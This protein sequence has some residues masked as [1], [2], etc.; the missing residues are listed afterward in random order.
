MGDLL[1]GFLVYGLLPSRA[2]AISLVFNPNVAEVA[3]LQCEFGVPYFV[4]HVEGCGS[5]KKACLLAGLQLAVTSCLAVKTFVFVPMAEEGGQMFVWE[6]L[7]L[8]GRW[9]GM[10]TPGK[11]RQSGQWGE[12]RDLRCWERCDRSSVSLSGCMS[13]EH[14]F[15]AVGTVAGSARLPCY[16]VEWTVGTLAQSGH[17]WEVVELQADLGYSEWCK[18]PAFAGTA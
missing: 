5:S 11:H 4:R 7:V 10:L 2:M 18:D 13:L 12:G 15:A 14:T 9:R 6:P 1:P 16:W 8:T 3:H 17:A